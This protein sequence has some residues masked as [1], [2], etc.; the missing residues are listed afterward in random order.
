VSQYIHVQLY[1]V[2]SGL[3]F[4]ILHSDM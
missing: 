3:L 2:K 4:L 1:K